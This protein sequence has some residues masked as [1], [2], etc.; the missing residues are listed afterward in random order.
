MI[1][2]SIDKTVPPVFVFP[3]AS[4]HDLLMFGAPPGSLGLVIVLKTAE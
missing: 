3:R 1:I 4:H 2:N